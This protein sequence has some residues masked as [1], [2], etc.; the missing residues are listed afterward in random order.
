MNATLG[1]EDEAGFTLVSPLKRTWSR[2]GQTPV[3]RTSIDHHDHLNLLGVLLVSPKGQK[4]RLSIKSYWHSLTG[5]ETIAFLKQI[6][7]SVR[8]SIVL[9]WDRHPIH[10]EG[11]VTLQTQS[12]SE[13]YSVP[14][15]PHRF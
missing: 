4:I 8:G 6:L 12:S 5:Q 2:R 1:L 11:A 10:D 15:A 3:I 9:V 14:E 7:Q 13:F